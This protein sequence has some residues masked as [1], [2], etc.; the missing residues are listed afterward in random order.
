MVVMRCDLCFEEGEGRGR[1][2]EQYDIIMY[3]N[4][5]PE[6]LIPLDE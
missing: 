5:V 4:L 6:L 2:E 3:I 1:S